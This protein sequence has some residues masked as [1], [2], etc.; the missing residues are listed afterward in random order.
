MAGKPRAPVRV[1]TFTGL[2][3]DKAIRPEAS[4]NDGTQDNDNTRARG[5]RFEA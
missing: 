4:G 1:A 3:Y 5:A 2:G